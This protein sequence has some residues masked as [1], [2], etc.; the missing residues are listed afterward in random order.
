MYRNVIVGV[1]GGQGGADAATLA[2]ALAESD[3]SFTLVY[4]TTTPIGSR[5]ATRELDV[6]DE[7]SLTALL[8]RELDACGAGATVGRVGEL[9]V[10]HVYGSPAD[11]LAEFSRD[12]DLLV[13]G[14]RHHRPLRRLTE[15]STSDHLAR[16]AA[17]PLLVTPAVDPET[18]ARWR[19]SRQAAPA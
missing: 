6:A 10:E 3:A 16:H 1:D 8:E 18:V 17:A 11:R 9:D 12:V 14:S 2:G 13:C 19:A 4:V 5:A 15:G 7:P